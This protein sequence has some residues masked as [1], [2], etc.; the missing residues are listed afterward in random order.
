MEPE[1]KD[2]KYLLSGTL[3]TLKAQTESNDTPKIPQRLKG[4]NPEELVDFLMQAYRAIVEKRGMEF[5]DITDAEAGK[6]IAKVVEWLY[7][8]KYRSTLFLQGTVGSGKTTIL[9]AVG[10]LYSGAGAS[11]L[12]CTGLDIYD[13]YQMQRNGG[14]GYYEL[15]K[16]TDILLIDDLGT[17]PVRFQYYGVDYTPVQNLLVYRYNKQLTTVITTNLT[18]GQLCERYGDRC[19]DRFAEMCSILRFTAP[20]YR[21]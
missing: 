5:K 14:G 19:W 10:A 18:D 21:K 16:T 13:Q 7:G 1:I 4:S 2:M 8:P 6:K 17:E 9:N 15:Y 12:K 20:S 11:L 3:K